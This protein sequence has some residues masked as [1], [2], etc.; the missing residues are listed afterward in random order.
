MFAARNAFM[1]GNAAPAA[2]V[3]FLDISSAQAIG[4][5]FSYTVPTGSSLLAVIMFWTSTT[6]TGAGVT[7]NST[8]ITRSV[9]VQGTNS[10]V[11]IYT[12]LNPTVGSRTI[13]PSGPSTGTNTTRVYALTYSNCVSLGSTYTAATNTNS[14]IT[15]PTVAGSLGLYGAGFRGLSTLTVAGTGLVSRASFSTGSNLVNV[16]VGDIPGGTAT[17]TS[18]NTA[19]SPGIAGIQLLPT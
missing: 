14:S 19:I 18:S 15:F 13:V 8:S 11:D 1:T 9:R 4:T 10:T 3:T 5:S 2:P 7:V 6:T 12:Q 16:N 17:A